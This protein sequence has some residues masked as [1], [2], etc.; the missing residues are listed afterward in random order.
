MPDRPGATEP[1]LPGLA[2]VVYSESTL[3]EV[4]QLV[5]DG[6]TEALPEMGGASVSV[7]VGRRSETRAATADLI[8][9]L[10]GVQY[11]S[12]QG[13]CLAAIDLGEE[14]LGEL[15]DERWPDFSAAAVSAGFAAVWSLPLVAGR[16]RG[17]LNLYSTDGQ[18]AGA[19]RSEVA[20]LLAAQLTAT[21]ANAIAFAELVQTNAELHDALDTRTVIGQ[22]QGV[23]MARE[24]IS[25]DAAFDVLRRASQ[26]TN[27]KL[28]DIA[29]ELIAG[30]RAPDA[31]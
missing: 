27:R 2:T 6:A 23:L 8:R 24:G 28:R 4:L 1:L 13:P 15:P 5:L 12:G 25:E 7:L 20:R 30:T 3:D 9:E 10:D 11:R 21:V 14:L 19:G 16:V 29:A 26:R 17:S 22:A 31:G 18:A